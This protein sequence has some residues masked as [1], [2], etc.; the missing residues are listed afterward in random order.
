MRAKA[1]D[2]FP[3]ALIPQTLDILRDAC[4]CF[5]ELRREMAKEIAKA[6]S[7]AKPPRRKEE[8]AVRATLHG[9]PDPML[10]TVAKRGIWI[11][12]AA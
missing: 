8:M 7:H 3:A 11:H 2:Y 10:F 6:M 12:F 5:T 4:A 9:T 1:A